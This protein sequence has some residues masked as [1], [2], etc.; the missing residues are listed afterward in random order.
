MFTFL[1]QI[2]RP[3]GN[4]KQINAQLPSQLMERANTMAGHDQHAM[5][6]MRAAA[7]SALGVVR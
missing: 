2:I 6:Q 5:Q 4:D 3:L 7:I 1:H